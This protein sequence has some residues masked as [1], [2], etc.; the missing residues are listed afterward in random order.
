MHHPY[1]SFDP[2]VKFVRLAADDPKVLAIKM[3]LYRTGQ[4]SP[5]A[6]ILEHAALNGKQVAVLMELKARFD[7]EAN[8]F[9][10]KRLAEAGAHVIYGLV[11]LKTHCKCAM[12]VRREGTE[13]HRY[14]HLGTGNYNDKT[15]R[16]YSDFGLFTADE[17]IG[18]DVTNLFNIITGYTRPPA[19]NH[20]EIA[21]TG[22]RLKLMNLLR[23]EVENAKS[24]RNARVIIKLNNIQ[25]PILIAELYRASKA[26]VKIDLIVRAICCLKPG[27]PGLSENIRAVRIVDRFLEHARVLYFHNGG[28]PEFYMASADWM[29]R[30]LDSR[31]ELLFPILD[32]R[33]HAEV[34]NFLMLQLMDNTKARLI[35]PDAS[36]APLARSSPHIRSQEVLLNAAAQLSSSQGRW[37]NLKITVPGVN[38]TLTA[39]DVSEKPAHG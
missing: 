11:G 39:R 24:G 34:E 3:T 33:L 4:S 6:Q 30:N 7:E 19:F 10:S 8:I 5:I 31:I 14:V 29:Q 12:V 27:V 9:L 28:K 15:A 16:L 32:K 18:E 13:I 22:L 17:K 37:G 2:V 26:G 35:Q 36:N 38:A 20:V 23:R 21:P 25:D 1:E